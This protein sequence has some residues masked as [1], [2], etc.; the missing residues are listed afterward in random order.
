[1]IEVGWDN[2]NSCGIGEIADMEV[3]GVNNAM[4]YVIGDFA[5]RKQQ[6]DYAQDMTLWAWEKLGVMFHEKQEEVAVSL[7]KNRNTA[8]AA[9]HGTGKSFQ[10]ALAA[11]WWV[12]T[13]PINQT[14]VA[15]TAPTFDQITD[16][17]FRE[18]KNIHAISQ[19]RAEKGILRPEE[20]LQGRVGEDN[21][22]KIER[23]GKLYTVMKGRKPPDNKVSD[24]FQG[25]HARYV[26][27]I[28]DEATGLSEELIDGLA[29]I[30]TGE[31]CRR[32]LISN[33]TNPFS[34]LGKIFLKPTYDE[35]GV[36]T[37]HRIHVSVFDLPTFHGRKGEGCTPELCKNY[38]KH[39]TMP[40]GLGMPKDALESMSGPKF[41]RDKKA[42][43]GE[44]SARYK[45]RVLGQFAFEAGSTLFSEEDIS[46]AVDCVVEVDF[47]DRPVLGVDLARFGEDWSFVYRADRGASMRR[48]WSDDTDSGA[49]LPREVRLDDNGVE[50][51][52]YKLR[53]VEKWRDAPGT[54]RTMPDGKTVKG[55][56][57]RVH[58]I[59]MAT[60]AKE[61]RV[62]ATGLGGPIIDRIWAL[63]N[64][65]GADYE[66]IEMQGG[67][68]SPDR[69]HHYNFR[70]FQFDIF[71]LLCFQNRCD[72]DPTDEQLIDEMAGIIY[73]FADGQSGGGLKIESKESMRRRGVK[74]PDAAD[75][76]W[77]ALA[78]LD[79]LSKLLPGDLVQSNFDEILSDDSRS[80]WFFDSSVVW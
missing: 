72:I 40:L 56:A 3:L 42:E 37:W 4:T 62:D 78:D 71:R 31:H 33:P 8:V 10:A 12:D 23:G 22:W 19:A 79:G 80:E 58:E 47:A 64:E 24:A 35:V 39:Q 52:G 18:V 75:A 6:Q 46:N 44:D 57:E 49:E 20:V 27:A 34:Y 59:A 54:T 25:I 26:L 16:I 66:I 28:G 15:T 45:A 63:R 68:A 5:R 41:V 60:G 65:A 13:H 32:L 29:N 1:V 21:T 61:V 51:V 9:G 77:Y 11:C 30:T 53:F 67:A 55:S 48:A 70:A 74:S 2:T 7:V 36:E 38:E 73:D 69:R 50:V 76:A 17:I 14:Y 43:Y